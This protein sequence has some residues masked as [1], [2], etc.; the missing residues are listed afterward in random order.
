[1]SAD[2]ETQQLRPIIVGGVPGAGP[3]DGDR[4]A[5][6]G[7]TDALALA[8]AELR[9]LHGEFAR[10]L[11]AVQEDMAGAART[12]ERSNALLA[13][14]GETIAEQAAT[15]RRLRMMLVREKGRRPQPKGARGNH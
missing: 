12:L 4:P 8:S 10:L 11:A 5:P 1:M 13:Q 7:A 2:T 6:D 9:R 14:Q 3:A 15:I